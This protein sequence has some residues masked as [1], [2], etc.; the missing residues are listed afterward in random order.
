MQHFSVTRD[1]NSFNWPLGILTYTTLHLAFTQTLQHI[2]VPPVQTLQ[3]IFF[4]SHFQ[5]IASCLT[6]PFKKQCNATQSLY[7][8][9]VCFCSSATLSEHWSRFGNRF[10]VWFFFLFFLL[11]DSANTCHHPCF[12]PLPNYWNTEAL[13]LQVK[14]YYIMCW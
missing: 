8:Y 3:R 7:D 6:L 1:C 14:V 4:S 13:L 10:H 9:L 12:Q 2:S 11:C 5:N